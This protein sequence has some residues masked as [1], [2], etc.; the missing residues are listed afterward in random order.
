MV[1][2]KSSVCILLEYCQLLSVGL[3]ALVGNDLLINSFFTE[4]AWFYT[5]NIGGILPLR[6]RTFRRRMRWAVVAC[7]AQ[8]QAFVL[9]ISLERG[10]EFKAGG[11]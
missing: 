9:L 5:E 4:S 10:P 3:L 6:L 2:Y 7:S 1:C 11:H 8:S